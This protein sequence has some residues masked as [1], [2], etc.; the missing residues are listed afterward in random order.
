MTDATPTVVH[1]PKPDEIRARIDQ[2]DA[3]AAFLRRLLRLV[4]R[5]RRSEPK[6]SDRLTAPAGVAHAG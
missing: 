5:A 4:T 2:L 6:G 1:I 3:E